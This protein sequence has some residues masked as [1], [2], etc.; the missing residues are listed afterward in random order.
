VE[1]P[2]ENVENSCVKRDYVN[3]TATFPQPDADAPGFT[4]IARALMPVAIPR[5]LM[6][7]FGDCHVACGSS[8]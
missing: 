2:V 7:T 4:V 5:M 6:E 8:Q 1:K 3:Q